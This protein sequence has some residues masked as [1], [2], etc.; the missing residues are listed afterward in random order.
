MVIQLFRWSLQFCEKL[1]VEILGVIEN[2]SGFVCPYCG[3]SVNIF[4][5]GGGVLLAKEKN[6]HFL[7]RIPIEQAI[8]HSCD[9]GKPYVLTNSESATGKSFSEVVKKIRTIYAD[10]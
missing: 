3:K 8:V 1:N 7:G 10:E 6:V 2:M 5:S 4:D 9:E